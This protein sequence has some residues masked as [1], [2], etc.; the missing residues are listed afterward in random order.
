MPAQH[1]NSLTPLPP[2]ASVP[3]F[4]SSPSLFHPQRFNLCSWVRVHLRTQPCQQTFSAQCLV[5][6]SPWIAMGHQA[7]VPTGV[8]RKSRQRTFLFP[9]VIVTFTNRRVYVILFFARPLGVFFFSWGSTC[10]QSSIST[11]LATCM[12]APNIVCCRRQC[13]ISEAPL[14]DDWQRQPPSKL[15]TLKTHQRA[16]CV[17]TFGVCDLTLP[18]RAREP[19]TLPMMA[20]AVYEVRRSVGFL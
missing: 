6:S 1:N 3:S 18:A 11:H 2:Y 19:W 4:L 7:S 20:V 10:D 15:R 16:G 14:K 9:P 12:C 13:R 17:H 5:T 8:D